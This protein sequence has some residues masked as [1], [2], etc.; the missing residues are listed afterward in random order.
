MYCIHCGTNLPDDANF[1]SKC[2]KPQKQETPIEKS[3]YDVVLLDCGKKKIEVIKV[4][5]QLTSLGLAEAKTLAETP[6]A[7]IIQGL[8]KDRAEEVVLVLENVGGTA[9]LQ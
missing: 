4:I 5:R 8:S 9:K 2:G 1:C 7:V 3:R 6:G